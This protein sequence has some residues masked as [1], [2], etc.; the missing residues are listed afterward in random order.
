[1]SSRKIWNPEREMIG[2]E[3]GGRPDLL[4]DID[5]DEMD[6]LWDLW[7]TEISGEFRSWPCHLSSN[8]RMRV[9]LSSSPSLH[10]QKVKIKSVKEVNHCQENNDN[11]EK[12][13]V[14]A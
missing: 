9:S 4:P 2:W 14:V 8:R 6:T 11:E 3:L 10:Q 13:K 5:D 12:F 7:T 1:M